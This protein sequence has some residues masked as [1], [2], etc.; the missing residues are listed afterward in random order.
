MASM[1]Y[2][3]LSTADGYDIV[4][5]SIVTARNSRAARYILQIYLA[6]CF[7]IIY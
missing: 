7:L 2:L 1:S 3:I 4:E 5:T 6:A